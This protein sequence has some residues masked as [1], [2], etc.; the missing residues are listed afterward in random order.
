MKSYKFFLAILLLIF[1]SLKNANGQDKIA[2]IDLDLVLNKSNIGKIILNELEEVNKKNISDLENKENELSKIEND[3]KQKKNIISKDKFETEVRLLKEKIKKYR[4]YKNNLV[5]QFEQTK[6]KNLGN[7]FSQINP[8]IQNYM[9]K[10]S[11]D[12]LLERKNVFIGK[13]NSDI[14]N[15]IIKEINNNFN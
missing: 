3:L 6:N 5:A 4:D 13:T 8:I 1:A 15:E 2:Y 14:T 7:F 10:N 12:I 9:D 11:I